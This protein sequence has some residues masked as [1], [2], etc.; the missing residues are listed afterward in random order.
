MGYESG[1]ILLPEEP[2]RFLSI[3]LFQELNLFLP[4][5]KA[6]LAWQP[7]IPRNQR[8]YSD[9]P[10]TIHSPGISHGQRARSLHLVLQLGYHP[11]LKEP[12]EGNRVLWR[13]WSGHHSEGVCFVFRFHIARWHGSTV[14][15]DL[16]IL[17]TCNLSLFC[18]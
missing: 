14:H 15:C 2:I 18:L 12:L 13:P 7:D 17:Q 11:I 3:E 10:G 5:V 6:D 1:A 16:P 4:S 9:L 8:L